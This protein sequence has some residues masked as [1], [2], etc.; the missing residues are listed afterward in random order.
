MLR[1]RQQAA[2]PFHSTVSQGLKHR[3]L[4]GVKTQMASIHAPQ[5]RRKV[6]IA[7]HEPCSGHTYRSCSKWPAQSSWTYWKSN[8][9]GAATQTFVLFVFSIIPVSLCCFSL[10]LYCCCTFLEHLIQ[11]T[12]YVL[13]MQPHSSAVHFSSHWNRDTRLPGTLGDSPPC[14]QW[15]QM[16]FQ[17][18]I[19]LWWQHWQTRR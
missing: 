11:C 4:W 8:R 19:C 6:L 18:N 9:E 2:C 17:N 16:V 1:R 3:G 13:L 5:L 14:L 12:I 10:W 7:W 15:V